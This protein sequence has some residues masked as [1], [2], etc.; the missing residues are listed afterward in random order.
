MAKGGYMKGVSWAM[1]PLPILRL[2][3]RESLSRP[4][5][6]ISTWSFLLLR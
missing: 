2:L 1:I 6:I 5:F 4:M 3:V